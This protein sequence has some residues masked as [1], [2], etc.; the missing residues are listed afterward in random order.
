MEQIHVQTLV[1]LDDKLCVLRREIKQIR[2]QTLVGLHDIL[3]V[4][5]WEI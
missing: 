3:Y 1:G 5:L 2:V 4:L